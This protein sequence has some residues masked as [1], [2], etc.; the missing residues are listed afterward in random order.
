MNKRDDTGQ[1]GRYFGILDKLFPVQYDFEQMLA[2]QAD[3]TLE[4]V[5]EFVDWLEHT[6]DEEP[7]A[8]QRREDRVDTIR[9][10]LEDKLRDAFFT[11]FDRQ[12]IYS[13]SRQMDYILNYA[14]ET[15]R[16]MYAFSVL[17]DRPIT[18]MAHALLR[19]TR[20]LCIGVKKMNANQKTLLLIIPEARRAMREIDD[21]YILGMQDLFLTVDIMSAMKKREI[22][23][24]LRDAGRALR[25]TVDLLHKTVV[26]IDLEKE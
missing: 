13:L 24:H 22:Y 14:H 3:R 2:D 16:E 19:G 5:E 10:D 15:S 21:A 17:P 7:V 23:H 4:G 18:D 11:P 25:S 26:V 6:P 12:D 20:H 1:H 8:L 9:Y